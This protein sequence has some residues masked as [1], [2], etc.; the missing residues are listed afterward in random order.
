VERYLRD[1]RVQSTLLA[2]LDPRWRPLFAT[3]I[4]LGLRKGEAL[5]FHDLRRTCASLL[6]MAGA[7]TLAASRLL[8]HSDVQITDRVYTELEPS[9]LRA[10]VN[11]MPLQLGHLLSLSPDVDRMW[12]E[13]AGQRQALNSPEISEADPGLLERAILD[14]NQWPLAPEGA[15]SSSTASAYVQPLDEPGLASPSTRPAG[16]SGRPRTLRRGTLMGP[17]LVA[18]VDG[19]C[20]FLSVREVAGCLGVS[21]ALV[22]RLC[23]LGELTH[24]RVSN[25]I[26]VQVEDLVAYLRRNRS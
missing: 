17:A 25:A 24:V 22:Y 14:S 12:T 4:F 18:V 26:R 19:Q 13:A 2:A 10:Q 1:A 23:D 11:R 9:W 16:R 3:C 15:P 5:R 7:P 6:Q 20:Q 8:R 21:T